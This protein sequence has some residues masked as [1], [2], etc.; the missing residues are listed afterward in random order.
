MRELRSGS[1]ILF[2]FLPEQTVDLQG[3]IWK[4]KDWPNALVEAVDPSFLRRELIQQARPW[5][6]AGTD[7]GYVA[8]LRQNREVRVLALN[9]DNGVRVVPF[10]DFWMCKRCRRVKTGELSKCKCGSAQFGQLPFVAFHDACGGIRSPW[11]P[12]CPQHKDLQV[13]LPGTAKAHEIK[14]VCPDC[15]A[16]LRSGFG[17]PRCQCGQGLLTHNVHRAA[18]VYTPRSLVIVNPPSIQ[19]VRRLNEAGGP[20]RALSWVVGG[21]TPRTVDEVGLTA[22]ALFR[23]LCDQGLSE[24]TAKALVAQAAA[25]GE[26]VEDTVPIQLPRA[27]EE[28]AHAAAVQIALAVSESRRRVTDLVQATPSESPLGRLYRREYQAAIDDAGLEAVELVDTFPVLTGNFGYTRGDPTPGKS[29][30]VPFKDARGNYAIYADVGN[31]EALFF[32]LKP[33]RVAQWLRAAGHGVRPWSDDRSARLAILGDA[34]FPGP[35]D[36]IVQSDMGTSVLRLVHSYSHRVIRRAAVFAGIDRNALSELLVPQHLGFFVFAAARGDFVLG[37]LQA[38]FETEMHR[39]LAEICSGEHRCPLDPGCRRGGGAC[40]ACL[41]IGEPSCRYFNR[42]L[43]RET[44]LS[45]L[46]LRPQPT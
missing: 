12:P 2:G 31:T 7:G 8:H 24:T 37:G 1:Q 3:R 22:A 20:A 18:S 27:R 5:E 44:L 14:F 32:R 35:G 15:G 45:Y 23:Q 28:G 17:T 46:R 13:V 38:V 29:R 25:A 36:D 11:I 41:H 39:L 30:L 19:R 40:M 6:A 4:V 26:L 34:D 21:M 10:P 33:T 42:G 43:D 9:K 16:D